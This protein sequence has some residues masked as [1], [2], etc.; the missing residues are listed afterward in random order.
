MNIETLGIAAIPVITV[1]CFLVAEL[2]KATPLDNKWLPIICGA[3]GGILG[4]VA[5]FI[6][7]EFPGKDYLT[8]IAIGIVSGLGA[9]G[10]HQI[11]KQLTK[12]DDA[13]TVE[14]VPDDGPDYYE[15]KH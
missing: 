6:M 2:I 10:A 7:P 11:Y 14:T 13:V 9:T 15:G 5:M 12:A 4:V 1:I 8:A 3:C